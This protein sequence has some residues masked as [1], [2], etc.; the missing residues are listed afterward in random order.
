MTNLATTMKYLSFL[1]LS[2]AMTVGAPRLG[3]AG[4]PP[5]VKIKIIQYR[6]YPTT[7]TV[8]G[9]TASGIQV[10]TGS[11]APVTVNAAPVAF[12]GGTYV[13][14]PS[15]TSSGSLSGSAAPTSSS[16]DKIRVKIGSAEG[17]IDRSALATL[18]K[19]TGDTARAP[20]GTENVQAAPVTNQQPIFLIAA[21]QAQAAPNQQVQVQAA[22]TQM[23]FV[24]APTQM[25]FVAAPAQVQFVAAHTQ[26]QSVAAPTQV[27]QAAPAS[28]IV[29]IRNGRRWFGH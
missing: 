21:P 28:T 22:P 13:L 4:H 6:G 19:E 18:L 11:A 9:G 26:V 20:G 24:A 8:A 25:Q 27:V 1:G 7:A 12:G 17:L 15:T 5:D 3:V 2:L 23:Q 10:V 14:A 29:I 16:G